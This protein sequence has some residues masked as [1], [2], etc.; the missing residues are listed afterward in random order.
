MDIPVGLPWNLQLAQFFTMA[1]SAALTMSSQRS[2]TSGCVSLTIVANSE[3]MPFRSALNPT[4]MLFSHLKIML[5]FAAM[6]NAVTRELSFGRTASVN[7]AIA[8]PRADIVDRS[9][10]DSVAKSCMYGYRL[11]YVPRGAEYQSP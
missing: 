10:A 11:G 5:W 8:S 4:L 7:A 1:S 2:A 3:N 9:T 6:L